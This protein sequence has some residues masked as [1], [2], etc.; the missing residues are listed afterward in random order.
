MIEALNGL[1]GEL[2]AKRSI[3]VVITIEKD[4]NI[5]FY[6]KLFDLLC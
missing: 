2:F 5:L 4:I 6:L 3:I 1:P